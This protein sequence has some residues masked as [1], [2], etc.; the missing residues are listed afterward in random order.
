MD[1]AK[2]AHFVGTLDGHDIY[3][4]HEL[5]M[6]FAKE[7]G[8]RPLWPVHSAKGAEAQVRHRGLGG[9][10]NTEDPRR[11]V[12]YGYEVA[13]AFAGQFGYS[14]PGL[15]GLGSRFRAAVKSL[16]EE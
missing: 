13:E 4:H 1:K 14:N 12:A 6:D 7:V 2:L 3:D 9:W 15:K 16:K 11:L 8:E 10:V 5:A